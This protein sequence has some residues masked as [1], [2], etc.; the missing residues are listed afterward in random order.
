[1][2]N[3][4][5]IAY[6]EQFWLYVYVDWKLSKKVVSSLKLLKFKAQINRYKDQ[7][8][9]D[10]EISVLVTPENAGVAYSIINAIIQ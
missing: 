1:M 8:T 2:A 5:K 10:D 3:H 6:N 7:K 4:K 9:D